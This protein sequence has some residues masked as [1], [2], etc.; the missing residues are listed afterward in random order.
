MNSINIVVTSHYVVLGDVSEQYIIQYSNQILERP[1]VVNVSRYDPVPF[2]WIPPN[3]MRPHR[4]APTHKKL[5]NVPNHNPLSCP[6]PAIIGS[7]RTR[8][9]RWMYNPPIPFGP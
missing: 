7:N 9:H 2:L 8:G 4:I 6:P 3:H 5:L 1:V